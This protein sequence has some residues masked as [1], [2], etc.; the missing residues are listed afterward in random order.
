MNIRQFLG[1]LSLQHADGHTFVYDGTVYPMPYQTVTIDGVTVT[2]LRETA[3]RVNLIR[4]YTEDVAGGAY[5]DIGCNLG[6]VTVEIG[7]HFDISL[8]IDRDARYIALCRMLHGDTNTGFDCVTLE[9]MRGIGRW[10]LITA[11]SMV[12]NVRDTD[13]F[14]KRVYG[15]LA[16]GG[17]FVMEGHSGDVASGRVDVWGDML[18]ALPWRVRL[19]DE[20]TDAGLNSPHPE[21]RPVWVCRKE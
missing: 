16:D 17:A 20:R 7:R 13:A 6:A 10:N 3:G 14:L 11:L 9:G 18:A 5:L 19:L 21:G 2:G 15:M 4:Q 12:E 1:A 8:G